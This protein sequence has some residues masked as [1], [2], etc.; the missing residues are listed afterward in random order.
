MRTSIRLFL[1][2]EIYRIMSSEEEY[3][4]K[5][6]LDVIGGAVGVVIYVVTIF[7]ILSWDT[8]REDIIGT[9]NAGK[10][11]YILIPVFIGLLTFGTV[12]FVQGI[13]TFGSWMITRASD[14]QQE[15]SG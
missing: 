8:Q 1:L 7:L 3:N 10:W 4:S 6:L 13:F 2:L 5:L 9:E 15:I 11:L 14:R 12:L